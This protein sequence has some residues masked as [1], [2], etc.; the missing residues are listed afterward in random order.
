VGTLAVETLE[1]PV[2]VDI[3][4]GEILHFS[5]LDALAA[6]AG[7]R[8]IMRDAAPAAQPETLAARDEADVLRQAADATDTARDR[9]I[10]RMSDA[11]KTAGPLPE[12]PRDSGSAKILDAQAARD[13]AHQTQ[14]QDSDGPALGRDGR[15]AVLGIARLGPDPNEESRWLALARRADRRSAR[16]ARRLNR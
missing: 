6:R 8:F 12:T 9:M 1:N 11:W 13:A 16:C 3:Q 7:D 14:D 2:A 5:M 10:R 15:H 4:D